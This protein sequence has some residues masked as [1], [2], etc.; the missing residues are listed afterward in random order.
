M[1][2]L[3]PN[4]TFAVAVPLT[5]PGMPEPLEVTFTFRHKNEAQ[6]AAW[7]LESRGKDD[8][9]LL[10]G[11]IVSWAGVKDDS[12]DDLPYS[13]TALTDLLANYWPAKDE[14]ASAYSRELKESK[15]KN[16]VR[17]RTA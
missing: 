11:L 5:V 15:T 2:K 8:V 9:A 4:P 17:L 3:N 16:F 10:H 1:F 7:I 12:G 14:I 6:L 13:L